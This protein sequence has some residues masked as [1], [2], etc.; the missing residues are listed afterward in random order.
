MTAEEANTIR[1][2]PFV[3]IL[4]KGRSGTTL[5]QSLL[6]S[7]PNIVAPPES[8]LIVLLASH[9]GHKKRWTV[10]DVHSF[11]NDL[12]KEFFFTI[13]WKQNK[14]ELT[15]F[16]LSAIEYLDYPLVCKMVYYQMRGS[17]E[18]IVL[19]SDKNPFYAIFIP[20]LLK[21]F[22]DA[23]FIHLIRDPRDNV[24]STQ[25]AYDANNTIFIAWQWLIHNR[26]IEES[27]SKM[28][29]RY[30]TLL[31]EEMVKDVEG[32]MKSVCNFLQVPYNEAMRDINRDELKDTYSN[33][34]AMFD[35]NK[36]SILEPINTANIEKWKREMKPE[37]IAIVENITGRY[38]FEKYKYQLSANN[39]AA[40]PHFKIGLWRMVYAVW[41]PF[42]R[43]R[44]RNYFINTFYSD[45]K[46]VVKGDKM[47]AWENIMK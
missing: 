9:Y 32:T 17:K 27:K 38:A 11:V 25:K 2:I 40:V 35:K 31:Y 12:Y 20:D 24:L 6:N 10:A 37:D 16:L 15:D 23:K 13:F 33:E 36:K 21:V 1:K 4:G 5:L 41:I 14:D 47:P 43:L 19:F 18:N 22:P 30:F 28:P 29:L 46:K 26:I 3:F 8:K 34:K 39:K 44:Q 7:H 42:T 45:Y